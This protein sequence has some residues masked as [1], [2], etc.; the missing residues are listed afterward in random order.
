VTLAG[1]D[2]VMAPKPIRTAAWNRLATDLD[3]NKLAALTVTRPA[4]DVVALAP[5]I[6]AGKVR[7]R[8]ALELG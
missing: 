5:D 7:G 4:T 8:I 3:R 2:S 6:L 1:V